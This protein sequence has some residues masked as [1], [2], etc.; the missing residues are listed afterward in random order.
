MKLDRSTIS[1]NW[2]ATRFRSVRDAIFIGLVL[3]CIILF[4]FLRD[5]TSSLIAGLVIPVTVA[6]TIAV[7]WLMGE[8]FNLMTLGGL[9]AAIGLVIDDAI[10][11]VENIV[12]H[13][14][15]GESRAEAVRKA[16]RELTDAAHRVDHHAG[17]CFSSAGFGQRRYGPILPR[18][19]RY[20]DCRAAH[21]AGAGSHLDAGPE[22]CAAA[23]PSANE[24]A[25]STAQVS[26][27]TRVLRVHR[28]VLEWA[29][30]K[31]L[32][33]GAI[34]LLLVAGTWAGYQALG[35]DLAAA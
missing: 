15:N 18:A 23:R 1:R 17:C 19:G 21:L 30:A 29:L 8:S 27:S 11:V 10:V 7:L 34:C 2:C 35:S 25:M 26:C 20:H 28:R 12:M 9:A 33:V 13:R 24:G 32:W 31:P 5:W 22:L 14:D 16:L 3:A 4:L 6:I